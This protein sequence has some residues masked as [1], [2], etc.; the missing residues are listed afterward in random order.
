MSGEGLSRRRV[1]TGL[2]GVGALAAGGLSALPEESVTFTRAT[3][4]EGL[5]L[6]WRET[7]NGAVLEG[8]TESTPQPSP[9]RTVVSLSDVM[10]GDS[11]TL[12]VRV[13]LAAEGEDAAVAP[14]LALELVATAENGRNDPERVAGDDTPGT[15]E[16]QQYLETAVWYDEG[17]LSVDA[18]GA[19]N[20]DR[21]A[22]EALVADGAEG[23]LPEV[24][25]VLADGVVLDA[26]P[27]SGGSSDCLEAGESVTVTVGWTFDPDAGAAPV[28][29][30]Q[31]DSVEFDLRVSA[32]QCE[33]V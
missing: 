5:R 2:T 10:P 22:G 15:G 8:T 13:R 31:G 12:S 29:V 3:Y 23:P 24:A 20:A 9:G 6:D 27:A 28:N 11:G 1:L 33:R 26:S 16:L 18:L 7:Y 32:T 17:A 19:E 14:E 21:D 25:A 30:A 4:T